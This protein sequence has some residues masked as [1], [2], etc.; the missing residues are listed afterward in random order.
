MLC[1]SENCGR[2]DQC[3]LFYRNPQPESRKYDNVEDLAEFGSGSISTTDYCCGALG[4]Y[5]LFVPLVKLIKYIEKE[6]LLAYLTNMGVSKDIVDTI[7]KEDR[8]PTLSVVRINSDDYPSSYGTTTL[9]FK[10]EESK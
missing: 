9:T 8:F 1:C 6:P 5:T 2:K 3:A 10:L 7:N 4:D